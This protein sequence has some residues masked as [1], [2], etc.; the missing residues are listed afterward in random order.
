MHFRFR[1]ILTW[2]LLSLLFFAPAFSQK[3]LFI[4]TNQS[5]S[6]PFKFDST[7]IGPKLNIKVEPYLLQSESN[8]KIF[9][10]L[11]DGSLHGKKVQ[12]TK[13]KQEIK[14]GRFSWYGKIEGEP[15]SFVL[16]TQVKN[17][18]AGH[19]RTADKK[20]YRISYIGNEVHEIR[21][22]EQKF[23]QPDKV[24][25]KENLT[26][27]M[28]MQRESAACCDADTID[29]M[30][31]YTPQAESAAATAD[32]INA[33]IQACI[34]ITNESFINSRVP[35]RIAL[36]HAEKVRYTESGYIEQD[37][38]ALMDPA[39]GNMDDVHSLRNQYHADIVV[40]LVEDAD[41][42][43]LSNI[44]ETL[45]PSFESRAFCV[46]KL[47]AAISNLS[48][49]HE[50]GHILGARH[51]CNADNA[52]SPFRYSHGYSANGFRTVMSGNVSALRVEYWSNPNTF[53]PGT[54]DA[55][56]SMAGN[57]Q[58]ANAECLRNSYSVVSQFRC[59]QRCETNLQPASAG[60]T[61]TRQSDPTDSSVKNRTTSPTPANQINKWMY[62]IAGSIILFAL[63]FLFRKKR[64]Q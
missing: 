52:T 18:I 12:A 55:T 35:A 2:L 45:D 36:V 62:L 30:V 24:A 6:V 60:A 9:L 23:Y 49:T 16:L 4:I 57:C 42:S 46:V 37:R 41:F 26:A 7:L 27:D 15:Q 28:K 48:F 33:Q 53:F 38:N 10:Y 25:L 47:S 56:G 29:V 63:F 34:D 17:V 43:G 11:P 13:I 1:I 40:L 44:M 54:S 14:N 8:K 58:A 31:V 61:P 64:N 22:I 20:I 5:G 3:Q 59:S 50:I 19:I 32:G 51:E 39:D 21:S